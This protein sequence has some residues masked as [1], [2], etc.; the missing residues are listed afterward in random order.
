L[1]SDPD[2]TYFFMSVWPVKNPRRAI[3]A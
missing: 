1:G 2:R 3:V